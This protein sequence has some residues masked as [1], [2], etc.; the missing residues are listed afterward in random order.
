MFHSTINLKLKS[1]GEVLQNVPS[2]EPHPQRELG[3]FPEWPTSISGT[4]GERRQWHQ[5]CDKK[6]T[7]WLFHSPISSLS[8]LYSIYI[9][10]QVIS[11]KVSSSPP[12]SFASVV[13]SQ[14]FWLA[15]ENITI[16]DSEDLP[17]VG[18]RVSS[19]WP[20]KEDPELLV[21]SSNS[22][23]IMISIK[24]ITWS[25][26]VCCKD[27]CIIDNSTW[28]RVNAPNYSLGPNLPWDF[29][30]LYLLLW[31]LL[32]L[33]LYWFLLLVAQNSSEGTSCWGFLKGWRHRNHCQCMWLRYKVSSLFCQGG[34]SR[35]ELPI[36]AAEVRKR[37]HWGPETGI[38]I[39]VPAV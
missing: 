11:Y 31:Q 1:P 21:A 27:T 10:Y 38:C 23:I 16:L 32:L 17:W 19:V 6:K 29:L 12:F 24:L 9:Y 33:T 30:C 18:S 28:E 14:T 3:T 15:R 26:C 2:P 4:H 5:W 34:N 39:Q 35:A 20:F 25:F 7:K 8:G 37:R 22:S 13:L 36:P